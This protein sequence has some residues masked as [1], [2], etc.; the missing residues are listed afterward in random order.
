MLKRFIIYI[1]ILIFTNNLIAKETKSNIYQPPSS[2]LVIDMN[3]GRVLH[4]RNSNTQIHPASLTKVMTLYIL[5]NQI[6]NGNFSMN[7]KLYVSNEAANMKPSKL[8]LKAG[9]YITVRD[10]IMGLI[11][12]SANDVA[13]TIAE[14]VAGSEKDFVKIM[15]KQARTLKM[16]NTNFANASG[17]HHSQQKTTANDLA[18][19]TIAIK[20]DFPEY[21]HLFSK[22]SFNFR[23]QSIMSTNYVTKNYDWCE[24][25]KT[26]YTRPSGFNLITTASFK[27]KKVLGIITGAKTARG[28]DRD[29]V[30][31]ITKYLYK[32]EKLEKNKQLKVKKARSKQV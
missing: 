12:K 3:T 1:I 25:L 5:F 17:W 14:N 19:L 31:M 32:D 16:Y 8:G 30:V 9:E 11:V 4:S 24:G 28:R 21:Y 22:K 20:E 13:K 2:S 10:A 27:N 29:M 6:K 7:D 23:G 18:K 15:N 26:G